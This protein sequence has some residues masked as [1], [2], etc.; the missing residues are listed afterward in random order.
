V[1]CVCV[2]VRETL[3]DP[4][5]VRVCVCVCVLRLYADERMQRSTAACRHT[6]TRTCTHSQ[7]HEP[8]VEKQQLRLHTTLCLLHALHATGT[9]TQHRCKYEGNARRNRASLGKP[10]KT[11]CTAASTTHTHTHTR[12]R[13]RALSSG[14]ASGYTRQQE[15]QKKQGS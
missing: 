15:M 3:P 6:H 14:V 9:H 1:C 11:K 12:A 7:L 2:C 5:Y 4:L 10:G 13:A 8:D